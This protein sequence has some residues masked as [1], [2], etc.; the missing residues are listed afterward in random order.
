VVSV[1]GV[2]FNN[3]LALHAPESMPISGCK[4]RTDSQ[5]EGKEISFGV[6]TLLPA[7]NSLSRAMLT[8]L[9]ITLNDIQVSMWYIT[10]YKKHYA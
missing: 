8:W 3:S 10:Y 5:E 6:V 9:P 4:P 7:C 1:C 2:G